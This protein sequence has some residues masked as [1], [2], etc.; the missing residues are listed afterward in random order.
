MYQTVLYLTL[1]QELELDDLFFKAFTDSRQTTAPQQHRYT[2]SIKKQRNFDSDDDVS[3]DIPV[4]NDNENEALAM[5]RDNRTLWINQP[6]NWTSFMTGIPP[7]PKKRPQEGIANH[8]WVIPPYRC[9]Q[10]VSRISVWKT[11]K[12]CILLHSRKLS[13]CMYILGSLPGIRVFDDR[14]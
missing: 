12:V 8:S 2:N 14:S 1:F 10:M 13:S 6:V 3:V 11:G 7:R 5:E 9:T 4:T